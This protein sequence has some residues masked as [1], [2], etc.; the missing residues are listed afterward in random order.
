M[1]FK[2]TVVCDTLKWIGYNVLANPQE[3]LGA[4][5]MN[6]TNHYAQS[7]IFLR[8]IERSVQAQTVIDWA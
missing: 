6:E 1:G 7:L 4:I 5:N 3:V 8:E 2:H